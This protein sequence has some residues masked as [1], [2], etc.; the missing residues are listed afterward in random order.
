MNNHQ[1]V[2]KISKDPVALT[3]VVLSL[4]ILAITFVLLR[5]TLVIEVRNQQVDFHYGLNVKA[6]A[7]RIDTYLSN[8]QDQLALLA[9][10]PQTAEHFINKNDNAL[11]DSEASTANIISDA[12]AVFYID[13]DFRRYASNL[14][15]ATMQMASEAFN[16]KS[17]QPRAIKVE[18]EWKVLII[19][20]VNTLSLDSEAVGAILVR[21]PIVGLRFALTTVDPSKGRLQLQQVVAKQGQVDLI[22]LGKSDTNYSQSF[23]TG[24]PFWKIS[25]TP[26]AKLLKAIESELPPFWLFFLLI[27]SGIMMV[28]FLTVRSRLS[29][30]ALVKEF[31][32]NDHSVIETPLASA[33]KKAPKKP[34]TKVTRYAKA[35]KVAQTSRKASS[36]D[37]EVVDEQVNSQEEVAEE[38]PIK[39]ESFQ[40]TLPTALPPIQVP[41]VVF[42]DYDIRGLVG[43]EITQEFALQL[44]KTLGTYFMRRGHRTIYTGRDARA[45]SEKITHS[46]LA[47]VLSTGCDVI[48]LGQVT[49]PM[50]N[51]ATHHY[52]YPNCGIMVTASH[53]PADY[54]G[55]KIIY[56]RNVISG[57]AL[58]EIKAQMTEGNFLKSK[59]K[60]SSRDILADYIGF[61]EKDT[62]IEHSFKLVVDAGNS[63]AGPVALK[64][65]E[66]LG[67]M[68]F[69][70]YCEIDGTFPN[71]TPNPSNEENLRD[72][73]SKV[74]EVNADLGLAFDGDGDR[75]VAISSSGKIIWPDELMMIFTRDILGRQPEA[76]I[77]FDVKSSKRLP[78][79]IKNYSGNPVMCKTGHSHVRSA[80][81]EH[82]APLGGE[83][84]GHIFF[85][86]ERWQGFDDGIYSSVRL[87][88]ILYTREQTLDEL[89]EGLGSSAYTPE[90]LIPVL[91]EEKQSLMET[92][93]SS[94][95]FF[96]AQI[97]N[98]DGLR[99]EYSYGWGLI[100]A[101]NTSPALT[102][103]FEA[104]DEE[105]L[106]EV[107]DAFRTELKP[108]IKQIEDYI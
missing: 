64:L 58:Q 91:E 76:D 3:V 60:L 52:K 95:Q 68:A 86:D 66:E 70:L 34:E 104:G 42:R 48:S 25:Y 15:F 75:V 23:D 73:Q 105:S 50:L 59:G 74:L 107:K 55:F 33:W 26:S 61:I 89:V 47:G 81:H 4:C 57:E 93:A 65:F 63:I 31:V 27:A 8:Y 43:S 11:N 102:L 12:E 80:V 17:P 84:S 90:I 1:L 30:K 7:N 78:A 85:N 96:G 56:E 35:A 14:G 29:R 21:L 99:V 79:L 5:Q 92:L 20:S 51:F 39:E 13:R 103:R 94:C 97:N 37:D 16:G 44:G 72:L 10:Q 6:A 45:S 98:L 24:N 100:R 46:L 38:Q 53:N 82:N 106:E 22:T 77:V 32:L 40:P 108:F 2:K 49:T 71:H 69:P 41:D 28:A 9:S 62:P 18:G 36:L 19:K 88:E 87:L 67:C 54:N 83:F 101:S